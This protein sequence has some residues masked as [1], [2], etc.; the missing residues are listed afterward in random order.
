MPIID[1][2]GIIAPFYDH[3]IQLK[4]L[5]QF[6]KA[7]DL[8]VS[9]V[10]LDVGGGTGRVATAL[11]QYVT[12][13][14]VVDES[15]SMLEQARSKNGLCLTCSRSEYL[16]YPVDSFERVIMVD[17]LHHVSNQEGSVRE[18]WRVVKPDGL[19][20]ILEPDIRKM[21]VKVVAILEK[22]LLMRSHFLSPMRIADLFRFPNAEKQIIED[23]FN[24][25]IC[26]RKKN[27]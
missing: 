3:A 12:H 23:G 9:G 14:M 27:A 6:I 8:P 2:F 5:D 10:L 16:P 11:Q 7:M 15:M 21:S 18:L 13:A 4:K 26:V 25:W 22:V 19:V 24:T 20:V 1:H 17:A